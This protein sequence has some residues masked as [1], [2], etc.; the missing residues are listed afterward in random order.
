MILFIL[1]KKHITVPRLGAVKFGIKRKRRKMILAAILSMTVLLMTM[2]VIAAP[3]WLH[4]EV[5]DLA[6]RGLM[7]LLVPLSAGLF[8]TV[9]IGVIAYFIEYYRGLYIAMLFGLGIYI[10]M[11]FDLPAAMLVF[12]V[13]A[14]IPGVILLLRFIKKYPIQS[15]QVQNEAG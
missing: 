9:I 12:G 8:V 14:A 11:T 5:D 4:S 2:G 6:L 10:D 13:L 15:G 7:D 3:S 1:G